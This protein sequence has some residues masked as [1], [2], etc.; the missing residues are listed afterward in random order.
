MENKVLLSF[1]QTI[2]RLA[3]YSYGKETYDK[4]IAGKLDFTKTASIEFP[5][6]IV[7][8]ASS[9]V[10]GFFE[11]IIRQVGIEGIDKTVVLICTE[12]LKTSIMDNL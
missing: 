8:A 11:D 9:F 1:D 7:K 12:T 3:G 5:T 6:Q 10:Q 2:T 4:Q